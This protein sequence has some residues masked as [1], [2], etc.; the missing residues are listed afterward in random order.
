M[1]L[2]PDYGSQ[3]QKGCKLAQ[4]FN[5]YIKGPAETLVPPWPHPSKQ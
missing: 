3:V 5:I 1:T 4:I 2:F